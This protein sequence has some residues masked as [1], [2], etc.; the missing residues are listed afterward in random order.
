MPVLLPCQFTSFKPYSSHKHVSFQ[1]KKLRSVAI[2]YISLL[3][4]KS[5][6]AY[7]IDMQYTSK[8][9]SDLEQI[10]KVT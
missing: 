10:I 3:A 9:N 1:G 7:Q 6:I 2:Q 4:L 8:P 5:I